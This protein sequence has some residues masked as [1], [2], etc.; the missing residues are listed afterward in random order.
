MDK[1]GIRFGKDFFSTGNVYTQRDLIGLFLL[2]LIFIIVFIYLILPLPLM[3]F[4]LF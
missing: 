1:V 3:N 4:T 2:G